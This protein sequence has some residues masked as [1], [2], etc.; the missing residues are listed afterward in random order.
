VS[1]VARALRGILRLYRAW[2]ATRPPRCRYEPTC[3]A[4]ALEAVERFGAARG[5]WLTLR[6]VGRCRPGGGFGFDPVPERTV[7][8]APDPEVTR[9]G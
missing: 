2:S 6:R 3:S 1:V 8:M 4:Y 9:V 5:T 7:T